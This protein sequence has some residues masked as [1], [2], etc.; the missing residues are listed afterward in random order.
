MNP[1]MATTLR[2][3]QVDAFS[4]ALFAGNPAA[5]VLLETA[6]PDA[7]MQQI[8]AE[9]NLSETAFLCPAS[10]AARAEADFS[11]RWFTPTHEVAL[12]GHATLA[13]AWVLMN[14]GLW[15]QPT[16]RFATRSGTLEAHH[17]GD[18][19][20]IDLPA[21]DSTP[22]MPPEDLR[23]GLGQPPRSVRSG[24]NWIAVYDDEETVRALRPDFAALARLHPRGVIVTAPGRDSDIVSRYFVPSFGI[25]E[26][27]VTGSAHCDL[28][29]FWCA[30]FGR[31]ALSARQLSSRGG[32]LTLRWDRDSGRVHLEGQ[33]ALY[34]SGWIHLPETAAR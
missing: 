25:D 15:P 19:I 34:L 26:D 21:R 28:A 10:A 1:T 29:P 23:Q 9:N 22:D 13:S 24:A 32:A 12:C 14:A 6:L 4:S 11:L 17:A 30:H 2:I 5:V 33:C 8:A 31:D 7:V 27:P 20:R 3:Y 18:D 16:V